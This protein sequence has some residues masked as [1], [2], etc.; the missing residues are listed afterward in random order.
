MGHHFDSR[1][2]KHLLPSDSHSALKFSV[3][4]EHLEFNKQNLIY[5]H[6]KVGIKHITDDGNN[7]ARL[8]ALI[9]CSNNTLTSHCERRNEVCN[10]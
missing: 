6:S 10:F 2:S 9:L 1:V 7:N 5:I 4:N 3:I 8:T